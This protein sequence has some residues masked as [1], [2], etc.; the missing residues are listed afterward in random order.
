VLADE[1]DDAEGV[2]SG[3]SDAVDEVP[4]ALAVP[5]E[6]MEAEPEA[7]AEPEAEAETDPVAG[8]ETAAEPPLRVNNGLKL[9]VA[10][11]VISSA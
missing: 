7:D 10:P 4:E 6:E 9:M 8:V 1:E 11:S 3:G 2:E 5:V